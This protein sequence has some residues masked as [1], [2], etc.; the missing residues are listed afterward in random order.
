MPIAG[1]KR[2]GFGGRRGRWGGSRLYIDVCMNMGVYFLKRSGKAL[3]T[4]RAG[5]FSPSGLHPKPPGHDA[6]HGSPYRPPID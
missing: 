1:H 4:V 6:L 3:I 5:L 2:T